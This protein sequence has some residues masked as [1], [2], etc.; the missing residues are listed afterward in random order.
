MNK[1]NIKLY[2]KMRQVF[3][4]NAKPG[5]FYDVDMYCS[6]LRKNIFVCTDPQDI[7]EDDYLTFQEALILLVRDDMLLDWFGLSG[8]CI[9]QTEMLYYGE[10]YYENKVLFKE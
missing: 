1:E 6:D 4:D 9:V 2:N 5:Y 8:L 3:L 7:E 10:Q